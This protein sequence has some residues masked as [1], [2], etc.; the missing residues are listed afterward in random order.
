MTGEWPRGVVDHINGNKMDNRWANLRD[1]TQSVNMQ[2]QRKAT[3]A[4]KT[5]YLGVSP[6]GDKFVATIT[7]N[8]AKRSLGRFDDLRHASAAYL[9][10]KACA[11]RR[12]HP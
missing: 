10:A 3:R 4:N 9:R 6:S 1:V 12:Q 8:K 5:G 7:T 11:A 2:N